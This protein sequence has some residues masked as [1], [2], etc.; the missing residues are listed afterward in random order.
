MPRGRIDHATMLASGRLCL[1]A[2]AD[3][4]GDGEEE[5]RNLSQ[6]EQ[7]AIR[8]WYTAKNSEL[9]RLEGESYLAQRSASELARRYHAEHCAGELLGD[10]THAAPTPASPSAIPGAADTTPASEGAEPLFDDVAMEDDGAA[11]LVATKRK[12][13]NDKIRC[14]GHRKNDA[15]SGVRAPRTC[16]SERRRRFER[17]SGG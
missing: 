5:G 10:D 16:R 9:E 7:I 13:T 3:R 17:T 8:Q 1:I 6:V 2:G 14:A 12:A 11:V 4:V 15:L